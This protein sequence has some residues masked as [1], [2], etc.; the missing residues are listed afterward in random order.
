MLGNA[1]HKFDPANDTHYAISQSAE[2]RLKTVHEG[3]QA[4]AMLARIQDPDLGEVHDGGMGALFDSFALALEAAL[5]E[6]AIVFPMRGES[7]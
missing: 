7:R 6:T 3:L 4:A 5:G 2:L 1:A